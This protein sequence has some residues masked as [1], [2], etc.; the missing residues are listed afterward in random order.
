MELFLDTLCTKFVICRALTS[1]W[2]TI[3]TET[4]FLF[5][6]PLWVVRLEAG[7]DI[8]YFFQ[9]NTGRGGGGGEHFLW[10]IVPSRFNLQCYNTALS[11]LVLPLPSC[12][13]HVCQ[14][15]DN[16]GELSQLVLIAVYVG[17]CA[18]SGKC[19]EKS[20]ITCSDG[21]IYVSITL[22]LVNSRCPSKHPWSLKSDLWTIN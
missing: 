12:C 8:R 11:L 14:C 5:N 21:S 4:E 7:S 6:H 17:W 19:T 10:N 15:T 1:M 20:C 16:P 18:L 22:W 2:T 9:F 13:L 3:F